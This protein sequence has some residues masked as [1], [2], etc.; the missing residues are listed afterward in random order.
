MSAAEAFVRVQ[1]LLSAKYITLV[2]CGFSMESSIGR[3]LRSVGVLGA[4][5]VELFAGF[6]EAMEC[7]SLFFDP[8]RLANSR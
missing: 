8:C 4:P 7:K 2:F 3:S 5:G 1:R 6:N